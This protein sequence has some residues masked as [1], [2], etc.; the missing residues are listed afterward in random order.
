MQNAMLSENEKTLAMAAVQGSLDYPLITKQMR[1]VLNPVGG[2]HKGDILN[3]SAE[4]GGAEG[5]GLSDEA[6]IAFRK[7]GGNRREPPQSMRPRLMGKWSKQDEQV[8]NGFNRRMG[9][10]NRCYGCGSEFH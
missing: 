3:I 9:E 8:R 10:R 5:E 6:W 2:T 4:A 1:Q 7:A